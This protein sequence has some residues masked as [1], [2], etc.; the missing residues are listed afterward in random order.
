MM[1]KCSL[2]LPG[3][4]TLIMMTREFD[5][6][7]EVSMFSGEFGEG[8]YQ[9]KLK[10]ICFIIIKLVICLIHFIPEYLNTNLRNKKALPV[11]YSVLVVYDL[12]SSLTAYTS[13]VTKTYLDET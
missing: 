6:V 3:Q 5:P 13:L 11:E 9:I 2:T 10:T 12:S 4:Q 8:L 1:F 7:T